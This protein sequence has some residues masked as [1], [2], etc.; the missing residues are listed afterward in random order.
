MPTRAA[1][2]PAMAPTTSLA[3]ESNA[4]PATPP[5]PVGSGQLA[6]GGRALA[7]ALEARKPITQRARRRPPRG[8]LCSRIR[9]A[10]QS[11]G[12][13]AKANEPS[14]R[15]CMARSETAAPARPS[16]LCAARSVAWFRLGSSID[17]VARATIM[18]MAPANKTRPPNSVSR[19][20]MNG[21]KLSTNVSYGDAERRS[22]RMRDRTRSE[23]SFAKAIPVQLTA[24]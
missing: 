21:R 12:G 8:R 6:V 5:R 7:T 16:T 9:R 3:T 2:G 22:E 14:P 15:S 23:K 20:A 1:A 13:R 24:L 4:S 11:T 10:P 18:A 17:H 19:F